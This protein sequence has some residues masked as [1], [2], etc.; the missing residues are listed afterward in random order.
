MLPYCPICH[1]VVCELVKNCREC[2]IEKDCNNI[3][4]YHE[5]CLCTQSEI[6]SFYEAQHIKVIQL[7]QENEFLRKKL[8]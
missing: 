2:P 7:E 4:I 1:K 3:N 6:L 8:G 5:E